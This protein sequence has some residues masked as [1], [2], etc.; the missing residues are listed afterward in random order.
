MT[1]KANLQLS[2][3]R[4]RDDHSKLR[5]AAAR[6]FRLADAV[7]NCPEAIDWTRIRQVEQCAAELGTELVR[8]GKWEDEELFPLLTE[9]FPIERHPDL[10]TSLWML[11]KAH[12]TADQCYRAYVH[13]MQAYCE[14]RDEQLLRLGMTELIHVC[15][16]VRRQLEEE[17][18]LLI[19]MCELRTSM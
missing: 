12:Q 3:G 18:E 17:T 8:H 14:L 7:K 19:P 2:L 10:P 6:A 5:E 9:L 11:E 13:D 16:L 15:R 1:T 4:L